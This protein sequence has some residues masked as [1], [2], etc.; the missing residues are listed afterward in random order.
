MGVDLRLAEHPFVLK[1]GVLSADYV[2]EAI[3][4][5]I[6]SAVFFGFSMHS[7][8]SGWVTPHV[9]HFSHLQ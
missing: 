5:L 1:D 3:M 9:T 6:S 4:S 2:A 8:S 7:P